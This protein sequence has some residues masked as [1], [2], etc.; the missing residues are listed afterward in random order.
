VNVPCLN[1]SYGGVYGN[2]E[3]LRR[4]FSWW[5][6]G[7]SNSA[8]Q[9]GQD[10]TILKAS[11]VWQEDESG[12]GVEQVESEAFPWQS[13]VDIEEIHRPE[14]VLTSTDGMLEGGGGSAFWS[15][16]QMPVDAIVVTLDRFQT[17]TQ[18]PW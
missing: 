5:R 1:P 13:N 12:D 14:S 10:P 18:V 6:W 4:H 2:R 11:T 17:V 16:L 8:I 9:N 15:T 3:L 7:G